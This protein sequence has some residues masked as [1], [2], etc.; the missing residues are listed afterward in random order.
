MSTNLTTQGVSASVPATWECSKSDGAL[1][2]RFEF[3]DYS[4]TRLF[5]SDL[6]ELSKAADFYPDLSFARC[7]VNV[8]VHARDTGKASCEASSFAKQV[9]DLVKG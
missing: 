6:E 5:L 8:T 3:E 9:S 1:Y 7:Y 2:R 4:E